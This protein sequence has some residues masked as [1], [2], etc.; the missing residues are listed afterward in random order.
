MVVTHGSLP[1]PTFH[2][3]L[4]LILWV[5]VSISRKML[6]GPLVRVTV[7]DRQ[8]RTSGFRI[9]SPIW[10][11]FHASIKHMAMDRDPS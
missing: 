9:R 3:V 11:A 2:L 8:S 4:H 1:L 5:S 7:S 6:A 10:P